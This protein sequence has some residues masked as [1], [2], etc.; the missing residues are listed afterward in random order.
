M[1]PSEDL[2][3]QNRN[4]QVTRKVDIQ[5]QE[6][7]MRQLLGHKFSLTCCLKVMTLQLLFV[8]QN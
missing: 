4:E 7:E 3:L 5:T 8:L 1:K 2:T 6:E